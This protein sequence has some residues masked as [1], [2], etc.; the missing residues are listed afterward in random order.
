[1]SKCHYRQYGP[2][3]TIEKSDILCI[4]PI[5]VIN[6]K[7]YIIIWFWL[8]CLALISTLYLFYLMAVFLLPFYRVNITSSR[9]N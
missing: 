2:S 6:E 3:G 7:I 4:L 1:M 8:V 5:N 9:V